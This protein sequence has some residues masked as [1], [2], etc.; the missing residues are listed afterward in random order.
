MN[1]RLE[2]TY[3]IGKGMKLFAV[4]QA[5]DHVVNIFFEE[6]QANNRTFGLWC[7]EIQLLN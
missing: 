1:K 5:I 3:G 7:V 4:P 6:A 2:K